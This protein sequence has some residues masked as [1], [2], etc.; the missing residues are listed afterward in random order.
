MAMQKN[1]TDAEAAATGRETEWRQF[2]AL[3][4]LFGSEE[5]A[6]SILGKIEKTCRRLDEI[7][8]T[9]SPAEQARART[10]LAAYARTLELVHRIRERREQMMTAPDSR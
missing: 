8:R 1:M 5:A 3:E 10:A 9:G 4:K 6:A 7:T 2:P